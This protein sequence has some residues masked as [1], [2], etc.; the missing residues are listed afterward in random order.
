MYDVWKEIHSLSWPQLFTLLNANLHRD[1]NGG[2]AFSRFLHETFSCRR[3]SLGKLF[4]RF[5]FVTLLIWDNVPLYHC[6]NGAIHS[7]KCYVRLG[8]ISF[9]NKY[10]LSCSPVS[11]KNAFDKYDRGGSAVFV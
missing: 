5:V 4:R 6:L 10:R 7:R 9:K 11:Y 2:F 3:L 1:K 8:S